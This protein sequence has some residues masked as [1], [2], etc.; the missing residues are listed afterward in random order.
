MTSLST[1]H[2]ITNSSQAAPIGQFLARGALV[3]QFIVDRETNIVLNFPTDADYVAYNDFYFGETIGRVANRVEN[4][5]VSSLDGRKV[6]VG[7]NAP[8]HALHGGWQ[9][10]GKKLWEG[11]L[12]FHEDE[13]QGRKQIIRYRLRSPHGDE[14]YPGTVDAE[15]IYTSYIEE[16]GGLNVSVIEIE[17]Q[18]QLAD[19]VDDGVEETAV[20]MT[21]HSY[22]N[23]GPSDTIQGT[24]AII[25]TDL[26]LEATPDG[27]PTRQV[28]KHPFI[29]AGNPFVLGAT[30]PVV[31]N[32]FVLRSVHPESIGLD[33]REEALKR[34]A[35]F[36]HPVTKLHLEVLT[37]EPAFQ[38]YTGDYIA[39]P[40]GK[41]IEKREARAGF[42][43]EP[44]RFVNACNV[45]EW[46][47]MT[48][49]KRGKLYGSRSVY[50]A[51]KA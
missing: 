6:Q 14:G 17:H 26:Y 39:V 51:W 30:A 1:N 23:L 46:R 27:I 25:S 8:P 45:P 5:S 33:T 40:S 3:H 18:V 48:I 22:F 16:V 24:E 50:R 37:T 34:A 44:G 31:D 29:S 19:G 49:L 11:P 32:C 36:H 42:C 38:F 43:V 21:N 2:H 13:A 10:W 9:G 20:A 41:G 12:L 4:A 47:G 35:T 7:A 28:I 15:V